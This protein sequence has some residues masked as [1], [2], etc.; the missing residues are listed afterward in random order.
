MTMQY[1]Y[2]PG[3]KTVLIAQGSKARVILISIRTLLDMGRLGYL[4]GQ[5]LKDYE[6]MK[7]MACD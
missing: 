3:T 4:T 2:Q 5:A 6:G 7:D 1:D